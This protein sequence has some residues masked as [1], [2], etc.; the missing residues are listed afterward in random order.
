MMRYTKLTIHILIFFSCV[1]A[2]GQSCCQDNVQ[3][4][5][6]VPVNSQG[7][8]SAHRTSDRKDMVWI[9]GGTFAMGATDNGGRGDEY[10]VHSV[11]VNGFWMDA[12][13]VTNAQFKQFIDATGY[14]T[15]AERVPDWEEIRKQLPAGT[16]KPADSLLKPASLVFSPP[17]SKVPLEGVASWWRWQKGADWRHPEGPQSTID[18]RENYPVVHVSWYDAQAYANWAGKRLPT[19]AEWEYAARGGLKGQAF[20][21]GAMAIEQGEI[22]A[23]TWQGDFPDNNT[24]TDGFKGLAPV[25]QFAAN[26]YGL[27]DMAGNVWEW[28]ADWY[29]SDYYHEVSV[30]EQQNPT[31]PLSGYDPDEPAAPKRVVRGGSFLCHSSYCSGYRVSSRMKSAPD[32][33]LQHTGFRCVATVGEAANN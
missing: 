22:K 10:P 23:N 16:P 29:R 15:T 12:T 30:A 9:E 7:A 4:R 17:S 11:R 8:G 6:A 3:S 19:E 5:F 25:K 24:G 28:C 32:T 2:Q 14:L 33:G 1:S 20:S 26:G 18:G 31:G 27:F 21:W 13:E